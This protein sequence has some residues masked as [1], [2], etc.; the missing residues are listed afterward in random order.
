MPGERTPAKTTTPSARDFACGQRPQY[1]LGLQLTTASQANRPCG[2]NDRAHFFLRKVIVESHEARGQPGS[3][4]AMAAAIR[5][6]PSRQYSIDLTLPVIFAHALKPRRNAT[7]L[8]SRLMP[9]QLSLPGTRRVSRQTE[10]MRQFRS[11]VRI[12]CPSQSPRS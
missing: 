5:G 7:C 9:I 2:E 12:S 11:R 6:D 3:S 1:S 4:P 8:T 10:V